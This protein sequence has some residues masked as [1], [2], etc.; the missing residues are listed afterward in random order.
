MSPQHVQCCMPHLQ[1]LP[2]LTQR[3]ELVDLRL[4][5][6]A[7]RDEHVPHLQARVLLLCNDYACI[8]HY[9]VLTYAKLRSFPRAPLNSW[10]CIAEPDSLGPAGL[11]I[12]AVS[13]SVCH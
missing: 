7:A 10:Q 2:P 3:Y 4:R 5:V 1:E 12:H 6:C 13:K 9:S 11:W 8:L